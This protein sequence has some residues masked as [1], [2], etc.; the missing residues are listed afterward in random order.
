[1]GMTEK[2]RHAAYLAHC[3][4]VK[5]WGKIVSMAMVA[6]LIGVGGQMI[7]GR[8]APQVFWIVFGG[9][10]D[11]GDGNGG[12][13][14]RQQFIDGG[15]VNGDNIFQVTWQADISQGT[16]RET[17]AAMVNGHAAYNQYCGGGGRRCILAGFSLGNSPALQLAA[18]VGL[19]PSDTKLFGAPQP[20]TGAWHNQYPDNPFVEP[21]IKTVG[22]LNSDRSVP[23]GVEAYYDTRDPYANLAPQCSGPGL[24]AV[25][26]D[27]HRII[28]KD[29]ADQH[30]WTG[31]D[32]VIMHE[33]NYV[34]PPGL[35]LSGSDPSPI[36]AGCE[37]NNWFNTPNSP[38][39]QVNP[40]N[41][42]LP[43]MP[44]M[45]QFPTQLPGLPT[46]G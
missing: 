33:V 8:T 24:F 29:E 14:A 35:P 16:I 45:P 2:V 40:N 41:P 25:S 32:G 21:W 43:G 6:V 1:M 10:Q 19:S 27:G 37:L 36:W 18:E 42:G 44:S 11:P 38:G 39:P 7:L 46:G 28:R 5:H 31:P 23:A 26:L 20:S 22:Q 4:I 30:V 12:G 15:W 13:L 34:A 9:N 3:K 17:D